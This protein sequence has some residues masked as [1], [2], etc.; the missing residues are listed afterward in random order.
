MLVAFSCRETLLVRSRLLVQLY[1]CR[2]ST[3]KLD[4]E[5]LFGRIH[6]VCM[7]PSLYVVNSGLLA[8]GPEETN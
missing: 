6:D 4:E 1:K 8:V 2:F 5:I 7:T 3:E